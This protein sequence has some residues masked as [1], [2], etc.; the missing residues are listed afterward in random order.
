[1]RGSQFWGFPAPIIAAM[2]TGHGQLFRDQQSYYF[3]GHGY[4]ALL[5]IDGGIEEEWQCPPS[6]WDEKSKS[7]KQVT[8]V[9]DW[10]KVR[11]FR[12]TVEEYKDQ[13]A[14][15]VRATPMAQQIRKWRQHEEPHFRE[16]VVAAHKAM[17]AETSDVSNAL[18]EASNELQDAKRRALMFYG[19]HEFENR[20]NTVRDLAAELRRKF[21]L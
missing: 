1:M 20:L 10:D 7:T 2:A 19:Q 9:L 3:V 13:V 11:P 17:E 5:R 6:W 14:Q 8:V 12:G 18:R 16:R 21:G 15:R 4:F